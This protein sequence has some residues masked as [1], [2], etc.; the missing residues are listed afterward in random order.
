VVVELRLAFIGAR[1]I[2]K[3]AKSSVGLGSARI[4]LQG[5]EILGNCWLNL[6]LLDQDSR[7]PA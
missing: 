7:F 1:V 2:V 4:E 6:V 3:L 5:L